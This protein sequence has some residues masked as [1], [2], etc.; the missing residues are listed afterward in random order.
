MIFP[1]N[2]YFPWCSN[3][4]LG[5]NS[6][7]LSGNI[8]KSPVL[9]RRRGLCLNKK[10]K[11]KTISRSICIFSQQ[12]QLWSWDDSEGR[13]WISREA[14][15]ILTFQQINP[16]RQ[17][18]DNWFFFICI[19]I[20]RYIRRYIPQLIWQL[21]FFIRRYIYVQLRYDRYELLQWPLKLRTT[22][23]LKLGQVHWNFV[24]GNRLDLERIHVMTNIPF[25][26]ILPIVIKT[27]ML[28]FSG[29]IFAGCFWS[30]ALLEMLR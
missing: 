13:V 2:Q 22:A 25:Y 19:Y 16:F 3:D 17:W 12:I 23:Y 21:I 24:T 29:L 28:V 10:I 30:F 18:Y 27:K 26:T 6:Q 15:T 7:N 1:S 20:Q 9:T 11:N 8:F 14:P 5:V 4:P